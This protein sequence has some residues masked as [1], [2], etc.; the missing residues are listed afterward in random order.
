MAD[1]PPDCVVLQPIAET[2]LARLRAA[3]LVVH[4]AARPELEG[5]RPV[6]SAARAVIT[7]NAGFSAE[8]IAAAPRLEVIG[9]HGTGL[10]AIDLPAARARGIAVVNTP[11]A[12]AQ[13]VA[14]L[15]FALMLA[16]ST[17]L[18]AADRAVR[19]HDFGWRLRARTVELS[20]RRLGLLG[21]GA[22]A[23][24]VARIGLAFGMEV[25]VLS[26]HAGPA[27]LA[28][29]G[30]SAARDLP[31]LLAWSDV[32]S[33]H[34]VPS[35]PPPIDAAAFA[36]MKPG[37]IL[38]NTARGALVDECALAAALAE[39]RIAAAGLDVFSPEPPRPGSP[40]FSAPNLVLSPH[41][42]GASREA[43]DRTALAV[44]GAVL[45]VLGRTDG[46]PGMDRPG[47]VTG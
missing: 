15:A 40:L 47:P 27:E 17:S 10:D 38:V 31:A 1:R 33:L 30:V 4:V 11:G 45:D 14:E 18:L 35:G 8:W 20:G 9:S 22:I 42:G 44:A 26:R 5:L 28:S 2:G 21:F 12:N 39:G 13:S 16:C 29:H 3:G 24:R 34:A 19:A 41:I 46:R 23:R 7:R 36:R 37:A 32:L 25:A 6:L 43:M